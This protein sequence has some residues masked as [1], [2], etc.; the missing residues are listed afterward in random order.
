MM[1]RSGT[2]NKLEHHQIKTE[3][4][5]FCL[6]SKKFFPASTQLEMKHLSFQS[7]FFETSREH[8]RLSLLKHMIFFHTRK[9]VLNEFLQRQAI[10]NATNTKV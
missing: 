8:K 10:E 7:F 4:C 9:N 3:C 5:I 2:Q 1:Q 6:H